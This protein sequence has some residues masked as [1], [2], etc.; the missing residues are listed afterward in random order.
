MTA[1]Q[2]ANGLAIPAFAGSFA[3]SDAF[4]ARL[5][6]FHSDDGFFNECVGVAEAF[7]WG[8]K[9]MNDLLQSERHIKKLFGFFQ[10]EKERW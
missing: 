6:R 8:G 7:A 9:V 5:T 2:V 4:S 3:E 1:F 10:G